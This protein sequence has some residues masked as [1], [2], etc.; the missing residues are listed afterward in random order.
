MHSMFAVMEMAVLVLMRWVE[1]R[2]PM[3]VHVE[4]ELLSSKK[5]HWTS[6]QRTME[7]LHAQS[8]RVKS[9]FQLRHE[10]IV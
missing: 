4:E 2:I 10:G 7:M 3:S 9:Q 8:P 6:T 1:R 5:I